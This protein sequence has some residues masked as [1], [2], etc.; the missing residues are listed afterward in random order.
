MNVETNVVTQ[1]VREEEFQTLDKDNQHSDQNK[2]LSLMR[3][4]E[5][6]N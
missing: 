4:S 6:D 5:E 2:R 3:V 1:M